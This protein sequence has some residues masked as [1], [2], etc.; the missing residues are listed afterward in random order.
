L[1]E[2]AQAHVSTIKI[3]KPKDV[4]DFKLSEFV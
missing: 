1:L 3:R 2:E 4:R